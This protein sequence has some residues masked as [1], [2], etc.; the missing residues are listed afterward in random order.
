MASGSNSFKQYCRQTTG[1]PQTL[2]ANP[3]FHKVRITTGSGALTNSASVITSDEIRS[4]RQIVTNRKGINS[5]EL[6]LSGLELSFDSF[7]DLLEGALGSDFQGGFT[8]TANVAVDTGGVFTLQGTEEWADYRIQEGDYVKLTGATEN[9]DVYGKVTLIENNLGDEQLTLEALDGTA[10]T[11][12]EITE[13]VTFM[14]GHY[15]HHSLTVTVVADDNKFTLSGTDSWAD[16]EV[17][18]GDWIEFAGFTAPSNNGWFNVES[19]S[20]QDIIIAAPE[21]ALTDVTEDTGIQVFTNTGFITVGV[22]LPYFAFE[23]GF[24]DIDQGDDVDGNPVTDGVYHNIIG[25]RVNSFNMSIQT[26][27]VVTLGFDFVGMIY[28]GFKNASIAAGSEDTNVNQVMDSFTGKLHIPDAPAVQ[29]YISALDFTLDNGIERNVALFMRNAFAL[30][31]GRASVSGNM[32]CF[33]MTPDVSNLF[34]NEVE[35]GMSLRMEDLDGHSYTLG[36][37]R[38]KVNTDSLTIP[39]NSITQSLGFVA[40]GTGGGDKKKTL[41]MLRQPN[42]NV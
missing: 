16:L 12:T 28:S 39:E 41:Y 30:E 17:E 7:D 5:P 25:S 23:E 32:T 1:N 8:F 31:E 6:S 10:L 4:D 36:F 19:I 14:T 11:T 2:Q 3:I 38:T 34:Q 24:T 42:P 27:S 35:F 33:F 22:N 15:A 26:D 29:A 21:V 37:P 18:E 40:L 9:I 13:D 20:G